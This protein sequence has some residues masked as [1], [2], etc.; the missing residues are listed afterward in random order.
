[1]TMTAGLILSLSLA[2]TANAAS[3]GKGTAPK[4]GQG[5][6]NAKKVAQSKME[7]SKKMQEVEKKGHAK[8]QQ[9]MKK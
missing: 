3:A 7:R 9:G 6:Q 5:V 1:M 2:V 4:T 8:R